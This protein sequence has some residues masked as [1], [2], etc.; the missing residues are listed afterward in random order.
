MVSNPIPK[1]LIR[2]SVAA[3]MLGMQ[4]ATLRKWRHTGDGPPFIRMGRAIRYEISE[5]LG[6]VDRNRSWSTSDA[7]SF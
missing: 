2:E 4:P 7:G 3:E 6:Y 1:V 5:V